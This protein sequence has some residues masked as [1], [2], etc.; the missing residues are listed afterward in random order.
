MRFSITLTHLKNILTD[1]L[2]YFL[3]LRFFLDWDVNSGL[4]EKS[5]PFKVSA[6]LFRLFFLL[7]ERKM[8]IHMLDGVLWINVLQFFH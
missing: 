5:N 2:R 1:N 3:F 7:S 6:F 8:K 4:S